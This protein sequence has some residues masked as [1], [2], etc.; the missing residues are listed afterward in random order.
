MKLGLSSKN[1]AK[2]STT[3]TFSEDDLVIIGRLLAAG[4][5]MVPTSHPA[6]AQIKAAMT[7]MGLPTPKG[8]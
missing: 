2:Q 4:Q 3:L 1:K 8:L 6:L 7:R 5:V